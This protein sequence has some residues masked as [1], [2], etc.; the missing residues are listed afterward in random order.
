MQDALLTATKMTQSL[1]N[2]MNSPLAVAA[3]LLWLVLLW[4]MQRHYR[5]WMKERSKEKVIY[6]NHPAIPVKVYQLSDIET[7]PTSDSKAKPVRQKPLPRPVASQPIVPSTN[8]W[9][10]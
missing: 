8:I 10:V 1:L 9:D 3:T 6:Q 5:R 7:E 4:L 2:L